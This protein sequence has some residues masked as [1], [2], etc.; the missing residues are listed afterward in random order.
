MGK[1][2]KG[3]TKDQLIAELKETRRELA[4]LKGFEEKCRVLFERFLI[5]VFLLDFKGR[6]LDAN[7]GALDLIGYRREDLKSLDLSVL[8]DRRQL[9]RAYRCIENIRTQTRERKPAFYRVKKATG[10]R[11]LVKAEASLMFKHGKPI[12]II[13]I[14]RDITEERR[15]R[16]AYEESERKYQR[17]FETLFDVYYRTDKNGIVT[18]IS[19]SVRI[20][21]GYEPEEVI[22]RP[23][24]EFY[25]DP[26]DRER[27]LRR[28]E[29]KGRVNDYELKLIAKDGRGIDVSVNAQLL[30]D[31]R[32]RPRGVE[33]II[34]NISERKRA[35][36]AL[37][38]SEEKFRTMVEHSLQGIIIVQDY[39]IVYANRA[40]SRIAGYS[41]SELLA[42][43]PEKVRELIHPED[44]AM[45]WKRFALRISGKRVPSRYEYRGIRKDGRT[46]W[47]EMRASR[48]L[49]GGR[50]AVQGAVIDITE[51][52]KAE[53][54]IHAAL[55]EKEVMLREI[56]HRVKNNMQLVLSLL[57]IQS[58]VTD[59]PK[60]AALFTQSEMRIRSMALIHEALYRS[61][62]LAHID[63]SDYIEHLSTHLMNVYKKD[64]GRI[65]IEQKAPGIILDVNTAI[66]CGLI[67]SELL[68]NALKHAFPGKR[69]GR[70]TI[71]MSRNKQGEHTLQIKDDGIGLPPDFDPESAETLGFQLVR[72]L[73][74]QIR[75]KF[76]IKREKGT[77]ILIR[78]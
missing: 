38:E 58:R 37:R 9:S 54:K 4:K 71:R 75:G 12:A 27:F 11:I 8:L 72:G 43:P 26:E 40:F 16:T 15:A 29:E 5:C 76:R 41:P 21:G 10:E 49:Y 34:R 44:R 39:R 22:G 28:L 18:E 32:G 68:T 67:L 48:I 6:F 46:I 30:L 52:K 60:T 17:I 65:T 23:V 70:I 42:L 19:P 74:R 69:S 77:E 51:R 1:K 47:L 35:E 20:Q 56:H 33:G 62:D 31:A 3:K 64:L 53:E 63:F 24:S 45:V 14:A 61:E 55:K 13:G 25:Q 57:R 50:P 36:Q 78:F 2:E 73:V 66:P 59:D 7:R